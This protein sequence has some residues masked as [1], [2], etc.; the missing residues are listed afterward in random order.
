MVLLSVY[1]LNPLCQGR[2][3][4]VVA[5]KR[6]CC[7]LKLNSAISEHHSEVMVLQYAHTIYINLKY[8]CINLILK[9]SIHCGEMFAHNIQVMSQSLKMGNVFKL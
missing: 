2:L 5:W 4:V 3:P 9:M 6:G 7:L 1:I 8:T